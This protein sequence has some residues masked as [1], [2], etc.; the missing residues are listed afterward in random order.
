MVG[1]VGARPFDAC[2]PLNRA[3]DPV[4]APNDLP[5]KGADVGSGRGEDAR[6]VVE[7]SGFVSRIGR[8]PSCVEVV[9]GDV[10]VLDDEVGLEKCE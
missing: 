8:C 10:L 1:I 5:S 6:A 4:G 7:V 2:S 9:V 3:I